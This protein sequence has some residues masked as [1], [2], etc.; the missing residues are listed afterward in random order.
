MFLFLLSLP[1]DEVEHQTAE[2][3]DDTSKREGNEYNGESRMESDYP[4]FWYSIIRYSMWIYIMNI[5]IL[6]HRKEHLLNN[7]YACQ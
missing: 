3:E 5:I 2:C 1:E 6:A 7:N 4:H